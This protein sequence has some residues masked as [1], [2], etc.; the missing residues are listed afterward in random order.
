MP[1][2]TYMVTATYDGDDHH[3]GVT[4]NTVVILN[5]RPIWIIIEVADIYYNQTIVCNV[6]TNATNTKNGYIWLRINGKEVATE[7]KLEENGTK[8]VYIPESVY[9]NIINTTGEYTMSVMFNNGTYYDY[10]INFTTF[11][12]K[13]FNTNITVNVTTPIKYGE[14]LFI[15][16][17]VNETATGFVA[18][19]IDGNIRIA[20][21]HQGVAKFNITGLAP[22]TYSNVRVTYYSDSPFFNGNVTNIT[23]RVDPTT[24][25]VLDVKV[26]NITYGQNATIRVKV[27]TD[28]TGNVTIYVDGIP[29]GTVN[30]TEGSAELI[31]DK[32]SGGEH[33]VNVTYNGD[34]SYSAKK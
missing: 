2:G 16:V 18:V 26:D 14:T 30:I 15:N 32:L 27:P 31:V 28:A 22:G 24:D 7:V 17:T 5:A 33:V 3:F 11:N 10:Q 20:Y 34:S 13:K 8:V 4:N 29:K 21:V 6:T 9:R 25:Y 19:N 23:F 1:T 12:V